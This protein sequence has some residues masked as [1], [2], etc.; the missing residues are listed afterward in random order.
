M[1]NYARRLFVHQG[2]AADAASLQHE[3]SISLETAEFDLAALVVAARAHGID[4][5]VSELIQKNLLTQKSVSFGVLRS[6]AQSLGLEVEAVPITASELALAKKIFPLV[7]LMRDASS[8]LLL[9]HEQA[10]GTPL[11]VLSDPG[12]PDE[13][14]PVDSIRFE[15]AYSGTALFIKRR[16]G[17]ADETQPMGWGLLKAIIF[18]ER[19]ILT[20]IVVSAGMLSA[21]ALAP[22]MFWRLMM[23]RVL[24]GKNLSTLI[25]LCTLMLV[26]IVFETVF[27]AVRRH[28]VLVMT[29]RADAKL[30]SYIFEKVLKLPIDFFERNQ[31]GYITHKINEI[32][33]V[34]SF[35]VGQA[36][37]TLLDGMV[38][39]FFFPVMFFYSPA[40]TVIVASV[41]L[42][43]FTIIVAMLPEYRRRSGALISAEAVRGSFMVQNIHGI[44]TVKSLAL[45]DRQL[46]LWDSYVAKAAK[47]RL[48]H[49]RWSNLLQTIV[50]PLERLMISGT[51]A[52]GV[53]LAVTSDD[54]VK[55]G[56]L[57]AFFLLAQRVAAPLV[58]MAQLVNHYDE[59][60]SGLEVVASLV[61]QLPEDGRTGEGARS[62]IRGHIEFNN[63]RFQYKGALSPALSDVTFEIPQGTTLGVMGRSGSG[64]TTITRLLQRLHSEYTGLIKLDGI[65]VREYDLDY[66]RRSM[67]VVLQDNFL[68]NGT[69]RENI[70]IAEPGATFEQVVHAARLAGAE[71]FIDKLPRGYETVIFEGSSNLSGGQRQR[72]AIARALISNPRFLIFDEATSAL[73]AE[74]EA[75]V[76]A[77]LSRISEGRTVII[78]SHRLSSLVD[79]DAIL[80]LERGR[81]FD[82]GKHGELLDRCEIYND[83]WHQQNGHLQ[84]GTVKPTSLIGVRR[85]S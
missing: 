49:G 71:E 58:Q 4:T 50:H 74:S 39:I 78:I 29:T 26:V 2:A 16:Y 72:I 61:N 63:V 7:V 15:D 20:D 77:N 18:R 24:I 55:I 76:N 85:V 36:F 81:V 32:N 23:D 41:C 80:V 37:G 40:L 84:V 66:L 30:A 57:F 35:L 75:I 22:I 21:L 28:L 47:L 13:E 60:R 53:Y 27:A 38:L 34:R 56:A 10:N 11:F 82:I 45:A 17:V 67:G 48:E 8:M 1:L 19:R 59:A 70:A 46:R 12:L 33:K 43:I 5:N 44:R 6:C 42:L 54:P 69:I 52:L 25:T 79:C 3:P 73:D 51:V 14:L 9:R 68:F 64:K 65:D 62:P 83:L 31:V